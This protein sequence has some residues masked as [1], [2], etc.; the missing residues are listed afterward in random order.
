MPKLKTNK[1]AAKR[2]K[3]TASGKFKYANAN[4]QHLLGKKSSKRKRN[5]R[6]LDIADKSNERQLRR[7]LPYA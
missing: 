2:F 4:K 5:L 7:M 3:A 1:A 6:H